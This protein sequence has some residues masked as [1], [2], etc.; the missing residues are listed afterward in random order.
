MAFALTLV[1][2]CQA[3]DALEQG[4]RALKA[5]DAVAARRWLE[6]AARQSPNQ[7][8]VWLAVADARLRGGDLAEAETAARKAGQLAPADAVVARGRLLFARRL[9][10]A[11]LDARRE[12]NAEVALRAAIQAFPRDAELRRLLGLALYAQGRAELAMDAFLA[13]ID[14][15]PD[16]EVHYSSIETLLPMASRAAAVESRLRAFTA[17]R[18]ESPVGWYLLGLAKSDPAQFER[19]LASDVNFWPAAFALHRFV[20]PARA[21]ELLER[22]VALNAE[23]APA[24]Y[25]L[26]QLYAQR[27]EREKAMAARKRHHELT[28]AGVP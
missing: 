11:W 14:L 17:K 27:G 21:L 9:G 6:E 28:S 7:P 20:E 18:P 8:M 15:A 1:L 4:L 22:V 26:A 3:P 19:A 2:L 24:Y 16:D 13:A 23:Y 25:S 5:N 10:N 12:K